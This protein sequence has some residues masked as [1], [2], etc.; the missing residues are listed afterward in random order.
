MGIKKIIIIMIFGFLI[1]GCIPKT[2]EKEESVFILFKTP[3]LKHADLGFIAKAKD[4]IKVEIYGVGQPLMSLRIDKKSVCLSLLACMDKKQ[5]NTEVLSRF[6]PLDT[7]ENIF[8]G[9]KIFGGKGYKMTEHG[10]EQMIVKQ[11][12]YNINYSILKNQIVFKD[13]INDIV[14]QVR[15]I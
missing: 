9:K 12:S 14:I 6:Y 13:T 8:Q 2:Y 3:S 10:F 1:N 11:E 15:K 5:F 7:L 4:G